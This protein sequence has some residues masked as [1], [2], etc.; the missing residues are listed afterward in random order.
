MGKKEQFKS[1]LASVF[2]LPKEVVLDLPLIS[3]VGSEELKIENYKGLVEFGPDSLKIKTT[4]GILEITGRGLTLRE[5]TSEYV[6][7]QGAIE[8]IAFI[9]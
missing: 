1:V 2:S 3:M 8:K 5:I 4:R 9:N 7:V 6:Q